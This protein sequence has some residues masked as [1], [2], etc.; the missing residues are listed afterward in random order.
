M[1][2]KNF[3]CPI[4]GDQ[5]NVIG[6]E[7]IV[8]T[9]RYNVERRYCMKCWVQMLDQHCMPLAERPPQDERE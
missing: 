8:Q 4:H 1:T 2:E 6:V 3:F 7:V 9:E 5:G